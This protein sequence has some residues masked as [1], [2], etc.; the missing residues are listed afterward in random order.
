MTD[1]TLVKKTAVATSPELTDKVIFYFVD[2]G[3]QIL[4]AIVLMGIV[5]TSQ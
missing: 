3:M 4:T 2:H 5:F 1:S